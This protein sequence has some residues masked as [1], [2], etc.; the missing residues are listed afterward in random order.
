[1]NVYIDILE[2]KKNG[3]MDTQLYLKRV[4]VATDWNKVD[5]QNW[6]K[7]IGMEKFAEKYEITH[8]ITCSKYLFNFF[9]IYA[10]TRTYVVIY[11]FNFKIITT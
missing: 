4:S 5:V 7:N 10:C 11:L 6:L 8:K 9:F 2:H 3:L 1:M